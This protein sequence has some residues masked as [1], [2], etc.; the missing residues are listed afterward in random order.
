[1]RGLLF[2]QGTLVGRE[3]SARYPS[4]GC[5]RNG[6]KENQDQAQPGNCLNS[7]AYPNQL[8]KEAECDGCNASE[9]SVENM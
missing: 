1:M 2:E 4:Q 5:E 8:N 7:P 3:A 9:H 6:E